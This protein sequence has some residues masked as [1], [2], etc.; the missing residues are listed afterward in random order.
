MQTLPLTVQIPEP[1]RSFLEDY[2]KRH[3]ISI[4]QLIDNFIEQLRIS[5]GYTLHPD[6]K[7]FSG[8]LPADIDADREY[9]AQFEDKQQ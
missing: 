7:E 5:E 1:N 6:L 3:Q 4:S 8:I 2:M 9:Y